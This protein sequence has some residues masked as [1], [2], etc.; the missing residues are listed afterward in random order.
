MNFD[1]NFFFKQGLNKISNSSNHFPS[2]LTNDDLKSKVDY[3][4]KNF[5]IRKYF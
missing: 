1:H 2:I 4:S 5:V 3:P